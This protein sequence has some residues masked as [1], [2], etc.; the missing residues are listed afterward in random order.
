[1]IWK[2]TRTGTPRV[3]YDE[4]DSKVIRAKTEDEARKIA[5]QSVGD[6]GRLWDDPVCVKCERVF[7]D[8]DSCE[9]LASFNAS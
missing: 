8:G 9:I 7:A 1:M 3:G 6:E 4:Y 2:L 5:N